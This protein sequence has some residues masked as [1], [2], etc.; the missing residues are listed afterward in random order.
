MTRDAGLDALLLGD[1][2][3]MR[4]LRSLIRRVAP[5]PLPVLIRGPRGSG[6][7]LVARALHAESRRTGA[8]VSLNTSAIADTM[9][10]DALFGHVRGAFTGASADTPGLL[11]EANGGTIFFD[12]ITGLAVT[13]QRKLLR[14]VETRAFRPVG[15]T[16]DRHSDFRVIAATNDDLDEMIASGTFRADLADRLSGI[17]VDV[18]PLAAHMSDVP[19]LARRFAEMIQGRP[20]TLGDG[21]LSELMARDWPGNVRQLR[22]T[23]ERAAMLSDGCTV[24]REAIV[25]ACALTVGGSAARG[26]P[27]DDGFARRRLLAVLD[28]EGWKV[29]R[30]AV[31][32]GIDRSTL[33]RRMRRFGLWGE[34]QTEAESLTRAAE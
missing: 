30:A 21:A 3:V 12:E 25:A 11:G 16:R 28:Q 19:Q 23:V 2:T 29:D 32:L 4:E 10:E 15:A 33:Y 17:M 8:L 13:G 18:P 20:V 7:E 26:R 27:H 22:V 1:S 5:T 6:K 34:R 9:L 14:A 31:V 24:Q